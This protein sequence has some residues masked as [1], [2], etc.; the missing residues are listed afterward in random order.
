LQ[1]LNN[2]FNV[3][4]YDVTTI[5]FEAP[6]ENDLRKTVFSKDGKHSQPQILPG[7]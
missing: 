4:F 2:P 6:D 3:V 7:L 1:L 5:Y